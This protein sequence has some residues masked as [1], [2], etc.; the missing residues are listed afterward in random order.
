LKKG[1]YDLL[2]EVLLWTTISIWCFAH[3]LKTNKCLIK[4]SSKVWLK[5]Q[6]R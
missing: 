4:N 6:M 3:L 1:Q 5:N 2:K